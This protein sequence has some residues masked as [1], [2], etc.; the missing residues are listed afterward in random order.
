MTTLLINPDV[1]VVICHTFDEPYMREYIQAVA[2]RA[3]IVL[4]STHG[5]V[6][7]DRSKRY[8]CIRRVPFDKLPPQTDVP[9][10][11]INTEQLSVPWK[12]S[13]YCEFV[14]SPRVGSVYDYSLENIR[15]AN[16][17]STRLLANHLPLL[18]STDETACLRAF[19]AEYRAV[20]REGRAEIACIG[21]PTQYRIDII[22]GL[23]AR[24]MLIDFIQ[25]F[26]EARDRRVAACKL[27]LNLHAGRAYRLWEPLRCARWLFAGMPIASE[28]CDDAVPD[29]VHVVPVADLNAL[30]V[31]LRTILNV[32]R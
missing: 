28:S 4:Y 15:I 26:G 18:E 17:N 16:G 24:G 30:V 12:F 14:A 8:I 21:S 10:V 27:L 13:E 20:P 2:G 6:L 23:R 11:F 5:G 32:M 7:V 3:P 29:E 25:G 9:V 31:R 1:D 19:M 22:A